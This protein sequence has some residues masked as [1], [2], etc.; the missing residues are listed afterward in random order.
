[1]APGPNERRTKRRA[2]AVLAVLLAPWAYRALA[3]AEV[4]AVVGVADLRGFVADAAIAALTLAFLL[5]LGRISRWPAAVCAALLA[6]GY[7]ANFE[8]VQ[9]LGMIASPLDLKY[10][11]APTFVRGSA[12]ALMHPLALAAGVLAS[13]GLAAWGL[14]TAALRDAVAPLLLG[15]FLLGGVLL[16]P[17]DVTRST[18]RQENVIAYNTDWL[19]GRSDANDFATS[20]SAMRDLV[21]A[22]GADLDAPRAFPVDGRGKNVLLI[23]LESVSGNYLDTAAKYQGR[24]PRNRM[25]LLDQRF[26]QNVGY[27]TFFTHNRRTNRG[28]YS[29][30]CGEYPR[31]LAGTPK[32]A[33]AAG[34]PWRRCLPG[35]LAAHGYH[36]VY[37]QT[38]PLGFM[39]KDSFM[40]AIGFDETL[41][42]GW[43]QRAYHRTEWG[44]DDRAFFEQAL[45]KLDE[46]E[47]RDEPWFLTLL[48]AGTHHPFVVPPSYESPYRTDVRR[49]FSYL[50]DALMRF[51]QALDARGLREDTLILVTSDESRGSFGEL[52]DGTAALLSQNWGFLVAMLPERERRVV[53]EPFAQSDVALSVVDYLGI[54]HRGLDFFGRSIFRTYDRGRVLF[55]GNLNDR[56]V[57]GLKPDGTLVQCKQEGRRCAHY[58]APGGKIFG[59][60]LRRI[61]D[62]ER[63]AETVR[64]MG[65]RSLPPTAS[66]A[67]QVPL[68][69]QRVVTVPQPE[70]LWV[71]SVSQ[72]AIEPD[73]WVE[74][75][76]EVE[77][78]GPTPVVLNHRVNVGKQRFVLT[79]WI[80]LEPQ[81]VFKLR[82]T[83]AS[84]IPV[85]RSSVRTRAKLAE[86][87]EAEL[88]FRKRRF[89]IKRAGDRP[90]QGI[91]LARIEMDPPPSAPVRMQYTVTPIENHAGYLQ[92]RVEKGFRDEEELDPE[93]E[94]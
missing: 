50:D 28:L 91:Q 83:L 36:T 78:R 76:I 20:V 51:F 35:V 17:V 60:R 64:D 10:F 33:V 94:L 13:F 58:Q 61:H 25:P 69:A 9:A 88:I 16:W 90:P 1:M 77:S 68:I 46:L 47:A 87:G 70:W 37:L 66:A 8:T 79:S 71:Q 81:Q 40:P 49:A 24:S 41:G 32:M 65:Q 72:L 42:D 80:H 59:P 26:A 92:R 19:A 22:V 67:L 38:A 18:W 85:T 31:L 82:Y 57:G 48:N 62:D 73:E 63:F 34:R 30:L 5:S 55:Y 52:E 3:M 2:A 4:S 89:E 6:L 15:G 29:L 44:V 74:V 93:G 54:D 23:V 11:D 84:D 86:P 27:A 45:T 53:G 43:F 39:Q 7:Y 75:D 14:R 21:P 56:M 12:L